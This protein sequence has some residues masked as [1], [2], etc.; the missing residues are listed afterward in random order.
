MPL[1]D[2]VSN[3]LIAVLKTIGA[4]ASRTEKEIHTYLESGTIVHRAYFRHFRPH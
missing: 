1:V 3:L 4:G 2:M